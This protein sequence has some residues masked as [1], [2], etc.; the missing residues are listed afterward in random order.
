MDYEGEMILRLLREWTGYYH[1]SKALNDRIIDLSVR[2]DQ[3]WQEL[4]VLNDVHLG[5]VK[6][7]D[8]LEEQLRVANQEIFYLTDFINIDNFK[9]WY[10][11]RRGS[12]LWTYNWDAKGNKS[13]HLAFRYKD[14]KTGPTKLIEISL[15]IAERYNLKQPSKTEIIERVKQYFT[16]RRNWTYVF[17]HENPLHPGV[18]DYWQEIDVSIDTKRGDCE[19][20]AILMHMIIRT[21]FDYYGYEDYKW[22]LV[23]TAGQLV[24]YGG[25]GY[26]LYLHDDGHYYVIEST[27]D[28][29]G[30]FKRTWLKTPVIYNN[31]YLN[32]W[33]FAS[34]EGS[35]RN[36]GWAQNF[37]A[38][39]KPEE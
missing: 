32:F 12:Q 13:V 35:Q 16:V 39:K 19:D 2:H 1:L 15:E 31:L 37:D 14:P 5:V 21:L 23:L 33:G 9:N 3:L 36:F 4:E 34:P 30:S 6:Q 22:R 10:I 7:R 29:E 20:L 25:H 11:T 28:L 26:N 18:V 24:G 8:E 17:D 38:L 27:F